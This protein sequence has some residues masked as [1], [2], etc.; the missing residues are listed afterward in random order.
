[1]YN[2]FGCFIFLLIKLKH[3]RKKQWTNFLKYAFT[4]LTEKNWVLVLIHQ[5]KLAFILY[6]NKQKKETNLTDEIKVTFYHE[7]TKKYFYLIP[8]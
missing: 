4:F 5:I 8:I 7:T 3:L 1:M 6:E 2:F